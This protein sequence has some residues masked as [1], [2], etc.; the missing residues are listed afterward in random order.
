MTWADELEGCPHFD[1]WAAEHEW[2]GRWQGVAMSDDE[3]W[4]HV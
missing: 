2:F 4:S 1:A 3:W